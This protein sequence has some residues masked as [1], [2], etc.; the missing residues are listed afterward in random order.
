MRSLNEVIKKVEKW[1]GMLP[2]SLERQALYYLK[3]YYEYLTIMKEARVEWMRKIDDGT[4][5]DLR[6]FYMD[7]EENTG[8][9]IAAEKNTRQAGKVA[10]A[11][12]HLDRPVWVHNNNANTEGWNILKSIVVREEGIIYE[13]I[14]GESLEEDEC[15]LYDH[16]REEEK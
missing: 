3:H 16:E 5:I 1:S 8:S 12:R 6:R 2:E 4:E 9:V 14:N 13:F 15:S 11:M 7:L 10:I